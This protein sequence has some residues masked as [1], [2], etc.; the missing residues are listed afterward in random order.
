MQNDP[1]EAILWPLLMGMAG[2]VA[3]FSMEHF[4]LFS[5]PPTRAAYVWI[6][7]SVFW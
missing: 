3:L 5:T 6:M 2:F 1:V 4:R 7:E